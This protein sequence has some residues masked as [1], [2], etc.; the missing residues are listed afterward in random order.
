MGN[1]AAGQT[2]P[3]LAPARREA[4]EAAALLARRPHAEL[5][6]PVHPDRT[7]REC[8]LRNL[9]RFANEVRP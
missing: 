2:G 5:D 3:A 4:A 9:R 6:A 8:R 1:R 7:L